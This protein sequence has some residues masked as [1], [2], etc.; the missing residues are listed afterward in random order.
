LSKRDKEGRERSEK[1]LLQQHIHYRA[2]LINLRM[3]IMMWFIVK[4]LLVNLNIYTKNTYYLFG[5]NEKI[6]KKKVK[7]KK[8]RKKIMTR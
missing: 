5:K 4:Y 6:N 8:Q 1:N 7:E 2:N 3:F